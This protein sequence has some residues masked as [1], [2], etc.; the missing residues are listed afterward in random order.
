[1]KTVRAICA[2]LYH[3]GVQPG[4]ALCDN[5]GGGVGWGQ[6]GGRLAGAGIYV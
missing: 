2:P 3:R 1:M 6:A 4:V 5:L